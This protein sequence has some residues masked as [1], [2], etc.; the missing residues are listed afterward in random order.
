MGS[1]SHTTAGEAGVPLREPVHAPAA[2]G[3]PGSL[4]HAPGKA[5]SGRP[6]AGALP[7][8]RK[9]GPDGPAGSWLRRIKPLLEKHANHTR[10]LATL[11]PKSPSATTAWEAADDGANAEVPA[12]HET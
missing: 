10:V 2:A 3:R 12:N 4:L 6:S 5:A 9:E 7:S 8:T 11:L 1:A